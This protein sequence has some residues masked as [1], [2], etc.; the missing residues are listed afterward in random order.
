VKTQRKKQLSQHR[1]KMLSLREN[2]AKKT[3][4][5]N[6]AKVAEFDKEVS[7]KKFEVK[8]KKRKATAVKKLTMPQMQLQAGTG[9]GS[10]SGLRAPLA[11]KEQAW[12]EKRLELPN[13]KKAQKEE[14]V[15]KVSTKRKQLV[16][17]VKVEKEIAEI[18]IKD[19]KTPDGY[20]PVSP[21]KKARQI[22]GQTKKQKFLRGLEK[23]AEVRQKKLDKSRAEA[24]KGEELHQ[25]KLAHQKAMLLNANMT[26]Q[27]YFTN[28][29]KHKVEDGKVKMNP[30]TGTP[31]TSRK[32][33]T[34]LE[35]VPNIGMLPKPA[36]R[37]LR[38]NSKQHTG[39]PARDEGIEDE[40]IEDEHAENVEDEDMAMVSR[41]SLYA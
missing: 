4:S 37:R 41:I 10:G 30:T 14:L 2:K 12:N 32:D 38:K 9:S 8:T 29:K 11:S 18:G 15:N 39:T 27:S 16:D 28:E 20:R 35:Y 31:K 17:S 1:R 25:K 13:K 40:G 34:A 26:A 19:N 21:K 22:F 7:N 24:A 6:K 3:V 23:V 33:S 36:S 5:A